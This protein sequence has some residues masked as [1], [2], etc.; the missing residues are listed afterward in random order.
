[1]KAA[2]EKN[3]IKEITKEGDEREK[4][5]EGRKNSVNTLNIFR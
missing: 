1:L 2:V 5:K 4:W 3:N